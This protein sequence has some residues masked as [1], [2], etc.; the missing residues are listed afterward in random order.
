MKFFLLFLSFTLS[1]LAQNGYFG[2]SLTDTGDPDS[3]VYETANTKANTSVDVPPPDVFLNASVHVGEID[4][5]VLNLTAKVNLAA[6][7][8][9]LLDFNAGVDASVDRVSLTIQNVTAKVLLEARLG[10]LLAMIEDI[11]DSLD[12]NPALAAL[13][14]GLSEI[15]GD[16]TDSLSGSSSSSSPSSSSSSKLKSRED[17]ESFRLENN[18]L[19]SVNDYSGNAHTNRKLAQD[20]AIVDQSLDNDGNVL[21]EKTVGSYDRDM[22]FTG[23]EHETE[24]EGQKVTE[25]MYEYHPFP[26]LEAF[27]AIYVNEAGDVVGTQVVSEVSG[28]GTSTISADTDE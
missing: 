5:E 19:Y 25:R 16:L 4:I 15:T 17:L 10:N 24:F 9:A 27:S 26:G 6:Q 21:G 1:A 12:L 18:I 22:R 14:Q 28:G 11:L 2:Y 7:V 23:R 13:G 8:L 20:G 3:A